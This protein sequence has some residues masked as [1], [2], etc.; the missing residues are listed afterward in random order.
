[1]PCWLTDASAALEV[2]RV[3]PGSALRCCVAARERPP[4]PSCQLLGILGLALPDD[5]DLEAHATKLGARSGITLAVAPKFGE[6]ESSVSD[7]HGRSWAPLV[8]MPETPVD[9]DRPA[10]ALVGYVRPSREL[11]VPSS[12]VVSECPQATSHDHLGPRVSAAD[13]GHL[14][15]SDIVNLQ[16][17][18]V[19]DHRPKLRTTQSTASHAAHHS[20]PFRVLTRSWHDAAVPPSRKIRA[21]KIEKP[22][23]IDLFCGAGGL[24]YSFHIAGFR[25][26]AAVEN[27]RDAAESY[28]RSFIARHSKN[29]E[30]LVDSVASKHV[31]SRMLDFAGVDVVIGGPPCQDFSPARLKARRQG[32]RA[33]LVAKYFEL[34]EIIQ[35]RLFLFENVPNLLRAGGGR[36]WERVEQAAQ[37]LG[38]QLRAQEVDAEDFGVP[39]RRKRLFVLGARSEGDLLA[40]PKVRK[41]REGR[42]V[43]DVIGHLPPLDAGE[44]SHDDPMHRA[45]NHRPHMVK[46]FATIPQGGA[47]RDGK[48]RIPCQKDHNGHYDTYG[49]MRGDDVAPTL[50]GGCTNPS[51]GRFIHPTQHRGLTVREA[52]LLQT[53]PP[54]WQFHGGIE[55]QSMQVG[56]AV[57][58]KLGTVFARRIRK[59]LG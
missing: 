55:S 17:E 45:R 40:F 42:T 56:N 36:Y 31:A 30:L 20:A 15:R 27:D 59:Q 9:E 11:G 29:T 21:P 25:I 10:A 22:T 47:W 19:L 34:I 24:S 44:E 26:V 58:A 3:Q 33:G 35:P 14:L 48:R 51:K 52:A 2:A 41:P 43:M 50:T 12:V 28:R 49:R 38:Y 16:H 53:F 23:A 57:P 4:Q 6:P 5:D 39:Q 8:L 54:D 37:E 46:Y 32:A 13:L 1:M 18:P 7:R